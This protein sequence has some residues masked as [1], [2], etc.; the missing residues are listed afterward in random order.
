LFPKEGPAAMLGA[1]I[2]GGV[3]LGLIEGV[4][5]GL[6]RMSGQMMLNEQCKRQPFLFYVFK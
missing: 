5:V 3:I 2:V 6:S 4:S 1:A